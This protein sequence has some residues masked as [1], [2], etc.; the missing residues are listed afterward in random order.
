MRVPWQSFT[1][2]IMCALL[3]IPLGFSGIQKLGGMQSWIDQ[4]RAFGYPIWFMYVIG[5]LQVL[6]AV[7]LWLPTT[8]KWAVLVI[9]IIMLGAG[10]SNVRAG[11]YTF[12]MTNIVLFALAIAILSQSSRPSTEV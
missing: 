8:R 1:L 10:L 12:V 5:V 9:L 7:G 3:A 4:F 6:S 11:Q 2:Y